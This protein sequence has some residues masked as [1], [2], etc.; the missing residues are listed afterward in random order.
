MTHQDILILTLAVL[1][2]ITGFMTCKLMYR[3]RDK[4]KNMTTRV[5]NYSP[6]QERLH[7][8]RMLMRANDLT[9]Y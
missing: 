2:F 6:E 4:Q 5:K 8:E 7:N 3:K 1:E 9:H